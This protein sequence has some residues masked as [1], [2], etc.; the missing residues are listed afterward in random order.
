MPSH[1]IETAPNTVNLLGVERRYWQLEGHTVSHEVFRNDIDTSLMFRGLPGD[2]CQSPHWGVVQRGRVTFRYA[3]HEETV[4]AGQAYHARPG[5]TALI[6]AGTELVQFS[7]NEELAEA[8]EVSVQ[9]L[10]A[11][12]TDSDTAA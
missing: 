4:A 8:R 2:R 12:L 5:H 10:V 6:E 3:D 9:N 1:S 7:P 11:A